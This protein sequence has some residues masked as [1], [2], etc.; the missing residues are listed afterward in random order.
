MKDL[1]LN[2]NLSPKERERETVHV[3]EIGSIQ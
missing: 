2:Q 1:E 3:Y